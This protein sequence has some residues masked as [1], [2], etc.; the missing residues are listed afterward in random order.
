MCFHGDNWIHA[1][2]LLLPW[3]QKQGFRSEKEIIT[4]SSLRE[5]RDCYRDTRKQKLKFLPGF[6]GWKEE[7]MTCQN[8]SARHRVN[9]R[10]EDPDS[11]SLKAQRTSDFL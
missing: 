6:E 10:E 7:E 4:A 8:H 9:L 1:N 5:G 3:F 11:G 2:F